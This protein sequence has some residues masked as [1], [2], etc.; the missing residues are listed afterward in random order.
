VLLNGA[1]TPAT[2]AIGAGT[3]GLVD[4]AIALK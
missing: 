3:V 4:V 2:S 1:A